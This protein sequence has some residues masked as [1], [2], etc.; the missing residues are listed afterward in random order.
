MKKGRFHT[1]AEIKEANR[2][3]GHYYFSRETMKF[4]SS[5]VLPTIYGGR[6]FITS[7]QDKYASSPV[8]RKYTIRYAK[9]DGSIEKASGFEEFSNLDEARRTARELASKLT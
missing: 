9:D 7:E 5:R 8:P 1:I 3:R 4:F 6:Y 2:I